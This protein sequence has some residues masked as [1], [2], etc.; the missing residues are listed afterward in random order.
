MSI[1][2]PILLSL[3]VAAIATVITLVIG[4]ALA[5][6]FTTRTVPGRGLWESLILLPL[7][8]PPTITGYLLLIF[9]GRRGEGPSWRASGCQWCSRGSLR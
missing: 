5:R 2:S 9:F 7:V 4:L 6:L 8:F 1:L 3:R